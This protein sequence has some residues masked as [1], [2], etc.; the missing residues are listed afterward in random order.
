MGFE[1][2]D[3]VGV[4]MH[5]AFKAFVP[6][7]IGDDSYVRM[8]L[9]A[10]DNIHTVSQTVKYKVIEREL[11]HSRRSITR[12]KINHRTLTITIDPRTRN[13]AFTLLHE[14]GH[15]LDWELSPTGRYS[16]VDSDQVEFREW[17]RQ[18]G[19]TSPIAALERA[20]NR[21]DEIHYGQSGWRQ[22]LGLS[23]YRRGREAMR[24]HASFVE[25]FARS[26]VQYIVARS[27]QDALQAQ[28][29]YSHSPDDGVI[30]RTG[31]SDQEF[32]RIEPII[33]TIFQRA[34][35]A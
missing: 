7:G 22:A 1:G 19:Q 18:V 24:Y 15:A 27:T 6:V 5:S 29:R 9:E 8:A 33:A 4:E 32:E 35:W 25:C 10:I 31:W 28:Y 2:K 34:S 23:R 20:V 3:E 13:K 11:R 21:L 16:S 26:Y 30:F 17:R 12:G 14:I